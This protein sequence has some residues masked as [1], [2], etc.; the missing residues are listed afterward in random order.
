MVI[1]ILQRFHFIIYDRS[2]SD[3]YLIAQGK[4]FTTIPG[5]GFMML[6]RILPK[7][8]KNQITSDSSSLKIWFLNGTKLEKL[9]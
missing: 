2:F 1:T 6:F 3:Y 7:K 4:N 5:K 9:L 8:R